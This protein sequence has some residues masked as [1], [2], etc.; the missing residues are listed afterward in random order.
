MFDDLISSVITDTIYGEIDI[1]KWYSRNKGVCNHCG[2]DMNKF[3][4]AQNIY[5]HYTGSCCSQKI[6][7]ALTQNNEA[8]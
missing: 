2:V 7:H 1:N 8:V 5:P 4:P 6:D 3:D